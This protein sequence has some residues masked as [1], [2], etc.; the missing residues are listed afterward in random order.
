MLALFLTN[1]NHIYQ[2][3][4]IASFAFLVTLILLLILICVSSLRQSAIWLK[5]ELIITIILTIMYIVATVYAFKT[6]WHFLFDNFQMGYFIGTLI[7][8]VRII[9][10]HLH[11]HFLLFIFKYLC[12][13]SHIYPI[14]FLQFPVITYYLIY[15]I[16]FCNWKSY[17][18]FLC[19]SK[20]K[21]Y[22]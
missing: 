4:S 22:I 5:V 9:H 12:I 1:I 13:K 20:K 10:I 15:P 14:P 16:F 11:I 17:S 2:Y 8:T 21:K 6:C 19:H 7:A 3:S 18:S